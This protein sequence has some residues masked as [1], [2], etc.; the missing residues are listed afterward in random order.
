MKKHLSTYLLILLFLAGVSLLL[1]PT[2]SDYW[3]S[4]HQSRAI[5]TYAEQAAQIDEDTFDRLWADAKAYNQALVNKSYRYDMTPAE[6]EEYERL[7]NI[8]DNGIIV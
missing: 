4:L 7:L 5:A 3:N 8:S 6:R 2:I 1:Y